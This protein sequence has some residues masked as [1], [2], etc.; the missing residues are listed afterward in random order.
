MPRR[1]PPCSDGILKSV[2]TRVVDQLVVFVIAFFVRSTCNRCRIKSIDEN[3]GR[4]PL[5][6][7]PFLLS[8]ELYLDR[9]H[10]SGAS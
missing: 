4:D 9:R 1:C 7:E 8:Q 3:H 2:A 6:M 10:V 5:V